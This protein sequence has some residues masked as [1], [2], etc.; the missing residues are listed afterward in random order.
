MRALRMS[1]GLL[2]ALIA[3]AGVERFVAD[4]RAGADAHFDLPGDFQRDHRLAHHRPADAERFGQIA[5]G[6]QPLSG[7]NSPARIRSAI[8]SATR[9]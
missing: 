8:C 5:L 1:L 7:T 4:E 3:A 2:P 9:S 6:R